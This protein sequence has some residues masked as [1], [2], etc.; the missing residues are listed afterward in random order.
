MILR[1]LLQIMG[2]IENTQFKI[3][4]IVSYHRRFIEL[5]TT[6]NP[7]DIGVDRKILSDII[8]E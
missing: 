5:F 2:I 7:I 8:S 1:Q 3:I 4:W 6:K